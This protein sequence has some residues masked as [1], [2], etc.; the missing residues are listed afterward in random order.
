MILTGRNPRLTVDN[1][2]A[3]LC[4][5]TVDDRSADQIADQMVYKLNLISQAFMGFFGQFETLVTVKK[6]E[7]H[8]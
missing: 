3:E 8:V 5:P 2:L 6:I 7:D 1:K 4:E